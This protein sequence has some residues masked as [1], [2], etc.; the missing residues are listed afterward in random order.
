MGAN[1][2]GP[3][4]TGLVNKGA[5]AG[6]PVQV[7]RPHGRLHSCAKPRF[8]WGLCGLSPAI[9]GAWWQARGG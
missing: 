2:G 1:I 9:P 7:R 6:Y 5:R 4:R 3:K 8:V